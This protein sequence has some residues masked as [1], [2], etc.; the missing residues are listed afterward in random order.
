MEKQIT[1]TNHHAFTS[2]SRSTSGKDLYGSWS[3]RRK[4]NYQIPSAW[5]ARWTSTCTTSDSNPQI[6]TEFRHSD[7][8]SN[9]H[10]G[11]DLSQVNNPFQDDQISLFDYFRNVDPP[12]WYDTDVKLFEI[13]R[14]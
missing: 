5:N 7:V 14:V 11:S 13:Q 12:I 9:I 10:V 8:V 3:N 2:S 1:I 6:S 4:R